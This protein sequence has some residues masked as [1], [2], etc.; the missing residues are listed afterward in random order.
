MYGVEANIIFTL[1][2]NSY[3]LP[4][5]IGIMY[6]IIIYCLKNMQYFISKLQPILIFLD[7][8]SFN[9]SPY[10]AV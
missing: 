4:L 5:L 8:F 6:L 9:N 2:S 3:H 1:F 7:M 10:D